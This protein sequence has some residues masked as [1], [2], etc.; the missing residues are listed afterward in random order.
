[1]Q[2]D[3]PTATSNWIIRNRIFA[4][5][6]LGIRLSNGGTTLSRPRPSRAPPSAPS[7]S[8]YWP[9]PDAPCRCSTA[10]FPD[11]EGEVY[12]GA[13]RP[14]LPAPIHWSWTA[15]PTLF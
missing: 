11:G 4:N 3:T 5:G 10:G 2:V 14:T 13:A 15:W 9:A 12:L 1:V 6:D 7:V 8:P